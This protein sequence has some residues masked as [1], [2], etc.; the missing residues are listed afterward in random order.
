MVKTDDIIYTHPPRPMFLMTVD[1]DAVAKV[2]NSFTIIKAGL[3]ASLHRPR[4]SSVEW[5]RNYNSVQR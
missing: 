2:M 5:E 1:V 3:Q 4:M